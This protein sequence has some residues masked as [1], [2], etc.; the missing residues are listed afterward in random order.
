MVQ[1]VL[2]HCTI[3]PQYGGVETGKT[4]ETAM[5]LCNE[6]LAIYQAESPTARPQNGVFTFIGGDYAS[7]YQTFCDFEG[8]CTPCAF[9]ISCLFMPLYYV[10][11]R[12]TCVIWGRKRLSPLSLSLSSI[13]L[14]IL[15]LSSLYPLSLSLFSQCS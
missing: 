8:L 7:T 9:A 15:S 6:I 5:M 1:V 12:M 11:R 2:V 13:S 14:S 4:A 10:I 3:T